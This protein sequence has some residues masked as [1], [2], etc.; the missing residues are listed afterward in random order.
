MGY[1]SHFEVPDIDDSLLRGVDDLTDLLCPDSHPEDYTNRVRFAHHHQ[2]KI[3][4]LLFARL[5]LDFF[6]FPQPTGGFLARSCGGFL[7]SF[8]LA[9]TE[10][11]SRRFLASVGRSVV[12][13]TRLHSF[14]GVEKDPR[15]FALSKERERQ[16]EEDV[17]FLSEGVQNPTPIRIRKNQEK[18]KDGH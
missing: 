14:E 7:V 17:I 5:C 4:V 6:S 1:E 15:T 16:R 2:G 10:H 11:L 3:R 8:S 9:R 13:C 18:E 12:V